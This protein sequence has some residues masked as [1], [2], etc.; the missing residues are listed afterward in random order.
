[1]TRPPLEPRG[2]RGA[3]AVEFAL[4]LPVFAML[5]FGIIQYGYYF[6][7]T[8]SASAAARDAARVS[9]V[10]NCAD[11]TQLTSYVSNKLG[12]LSYSGLSVA[13]TFSPAREVGN[14]VTVTV[15]FQ[16]L[17]LRFPFVPVPNSGEVSR[18]FDTRV[19]DLDSGTCT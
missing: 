4:V 17:N 8:Q 18:T 19:E 14:T 1:M 7:A 6:F 3:V 16:T 2:Q 5:V 12:G 13:R 15:S 9:A 10:G 11:D